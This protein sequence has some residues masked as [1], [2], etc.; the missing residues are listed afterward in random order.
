[1]HCK[2]ALIK[3][4]SFFSFGKRI[5]SRVTGFLL[6]SSNSFSYLVTKKAEGSLLGI[7]TSVRINVLSAAIKT[8]KK[9][10]FSDSLKCLLARQDTR[11]HELYAA[12]QRRMKYVCVSE[13]V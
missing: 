7:L 3:Q 13:Q 1:M 10:T 9:L 5:T 12:A 6:C 2:L 4:Y 8:G 11:I